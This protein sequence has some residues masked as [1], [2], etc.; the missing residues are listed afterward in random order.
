[1]LLPRES[2]SKFRRWQIPD[3]IALHTVSVPCRIYLVL[4]YL[5]VYQTT[6]SNK[7]SFVPLRI[8]LVNHKNILHWITRRWYLVSSPWGVF[9]NQSI[10]ILPLKGILVVSSPCRIILVILNLLTILSLTR[11]VLVSMHTCRESFVHQA[12]MRDTEKLLAQLKLSCIPKK[13][14]VSVM[15]IIQTTF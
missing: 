1:M 12:G 14:F 4:T 8:I 5:I 15:I 9:V 6:Q 2:F 3:C 7:L 10:P 11:M 13:S